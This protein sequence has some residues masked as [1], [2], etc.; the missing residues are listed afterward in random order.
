[1]QKVK[2]TTGASA[3]DRAPNLDVRFASHR[4][5]CREKRDH[6]STLGRCPAKSGRERDL[7]SSPMAALRPLS[8]RTLHDSA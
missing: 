8:F 3:L 5:P 2:R 6:V 1:M 4:D 7:L